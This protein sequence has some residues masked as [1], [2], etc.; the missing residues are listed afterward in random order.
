MSSTAELGYDEEL[1]VDL[2]KD[3]GERQGA[4]FPTE[5]ILILL[6]DGLFHRI[7]LSECG[8]E[9]HGSPAGGVCALVV[10]QLAQGLSQPVPGL[11]PEPSVRRRG[12]RS[13]DQGSPLARW[14]GPA[15]LQ[16]ALGG[17]EGQLHEES[18]VG[19]ED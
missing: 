19:L 4:A 13:G 8:I 18:V 9:L 3:P 16:A 1:I 10:L 17:V 12:E 2:E 5:Q 7:F 14:D 6:G 11:G 15:E